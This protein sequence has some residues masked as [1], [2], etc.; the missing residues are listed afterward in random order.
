MGNY[1]DLT[2]A[3]QCVVTGT[4]R[5]RR[6]RR[7]ERLNG[8]L[9]KGYEL[10]HTCEDERC[11]NLAHL[12]PVTR[13]EHMALDGRIKGEAAAAAK[14]AITHCAHGHE[15][16]PENTGTQKRANGKTQRYCRT[17]RRVAM[18]RRREVMP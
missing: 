11:S 16:T 4:N 18:R 5:S 8:K 17:C 10:H 6:R 2:E 1:G 13:A 3:E 14:R 15:F 9:P 7:W 12:F